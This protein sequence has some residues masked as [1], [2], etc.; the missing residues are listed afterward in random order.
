RGRD[1]RR[2]ITAKIYNNLGATGDSAAI[3]VTDANAV[4]RG[5]DEIMR[6]EGSYSGALDP[7][8]SLNYNSAVDLF[9]G[10]ATNYIPVAIGMYERVLR[11]FPS[12]ATTMNVVRRHLITAVTRLGEG[13]ILLGNQRFVDALAGPGGSYGT[14]DINNA[15]TK[16]DQARQGF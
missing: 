1:C 11:A 12:H 5:A 13:Y 9:I 16:L 15:I 10:T 2:S 6:Q 3:F 4:I 14:L 7:A 8:T